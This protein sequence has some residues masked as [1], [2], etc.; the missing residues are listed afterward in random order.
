[1][2]LQGIP[3]IADFISTQLPAAH[4]TLIG[5]DGVDGSGK[6]TFA[7]TLAMSFP[8]RQTAVIH[9]D[10]FLNPPEVRHRRGRHS[11][12]GFWLDSYD[13]EALWRD[14]IEPLLPSGTGI[15]RAASFDPSK[16]KALQPSPQQ[17]ATDTVVIIEGMFLHLDELVNVWDLSLFL[18]VPF[19]ETARR[20]A[21][22]DGTEA[23]PEHPSMRR[24]VGGQR[25]YFAAA[26]PW[27]RADLVIDN[28]DPGFPKVIDPAQSSAIG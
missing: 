11:P 5:I 27:E 13:Y 19:D 12:E 7:N 10:D 23:D 2:D 26:R 28:S 22:R 18:D 16:D 3:A 24:Y 15:Y 8:S 21:T 4:R 6:T 25:M 14:V 1:M 20:M 17:S 9:V